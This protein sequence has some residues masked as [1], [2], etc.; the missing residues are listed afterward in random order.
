MSIVCAHVKNLESCLRTSYTK[1]IKCTV[2][3]E[4]MTPHFLLPA[5]KATIGWTWNKF[6]YNRISWV[7]VIVSEAQ[8][9]MS[10]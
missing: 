10:S 9:I 6:C 2:A 4:F 1:R 7:S 5:A 3:C 8:R